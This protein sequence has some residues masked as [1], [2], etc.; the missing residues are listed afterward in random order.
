[1]RAITILPLL[2]L[3]APLSPG[4]A[5]ETAIGHWNGCLVVTAPSGADDVNL[6][7]RMKQRLSVDFVETPLTDVAAFLRTVTDCNIVLDPKVLAAD[8]RV[9]LKASDM[10]LGSVLRWVTELTKI[11]MGFVDGAIWLSQE[12]YQGASRTVLYDVSDLVMPRRDF[13][14]PELDISQPGGAGA[15]L[16]PAAQDEAQ[17][18]TSV[19]ELED[20]LHKVVLKDR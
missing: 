18:T 4:A 15:R 5:A 1:M 14:G 2:A 3:F 17:P 12:P 13:P 8:P 6:G 9:T 19:E 11:H 10:E 16:Q 7:R 20:L